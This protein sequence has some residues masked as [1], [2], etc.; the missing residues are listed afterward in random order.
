MIRNLLILLITVTSILSGEKRETAHDT[1]LSHLKEIKEDAI[2][3]GEGKKEVDVFIDPLCPHSKKFMSMVFEN[4]KLLSHY[5][6]HLYLYPIP[7]LKSNEVIAGIYHADKALE[8]LYR[9]MVEERVIQSTV[10]QT[11]TSKID[12]ISKVAEAIHVTKRPFI[13]VVDSTAGKE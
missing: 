9:V 1:I 3:L 11:V 6:L 7:R 8:R 10:D 13:Y 4:Q 12:R 5:R 2:V